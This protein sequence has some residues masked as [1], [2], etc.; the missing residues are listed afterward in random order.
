MFFV[1]MW[2]VPTW[3][4][5]WQRLETLSHLFITGGSAHSG[6]CYS[7][8]GRLSRILTD[9]ISAATAITRVVKLHRFR[10]SRLGHHK[11]TRGGTSLGPG[12]SSLPMRMVGKCEADVVLEISCF[13]LSK[14]GYHCGLTSPHSQTTSRVCE[15][16]QVRLCGKTSFLEEAIG[17]MSGK[18]PSL[19][20]EI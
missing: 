17:R 20:P 19:G 9:N 15:S 11:S 13:F 4:C 18:S 12:W 10:A 6:A 2:P 14:L 1:R 3:P 8:Q 16:F 5:T 7:F